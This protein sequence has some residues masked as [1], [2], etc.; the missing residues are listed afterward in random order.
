MRN[1]IKVLVLRI[2]YKSKIDYSVSISKKTVL[3]YKTFIGRHCDIHCGKIGKYTYI[4]N[5]THLT[6]NVTS[7]GAFC[8]IGEGAKIGLVSHPMNYISTHNFIHDPYFDFVKQQ[9]YKA[10]EQAGP[11]VIGNDVWIGSNAVVLA[12]LTIGDGAVIGAGAVVTKDVPPY[13]VVAGVP[14]EIKKFR[15]DP[16]MIAKLQDIKWWDF[17]E[18]TLR[19]NID[20]F[21]NNDHFIKKFS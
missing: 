6:Y 21:M 1:F 17:D 11:T 20:L 3:G 13:A 8:S 18:G 2:F 15:F 4:N 14:A 9:K 16:D 10:S 5:N 7:I 12:G 19:E